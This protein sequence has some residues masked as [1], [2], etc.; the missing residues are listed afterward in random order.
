MEN[1]HF[2]RDISHV[3]M[4][5]LSTI[6][7]NIPA[8]A[9]SEAPRCHEKLRVLLHLQAAKFHVAPGA[10]HLGGG[11]GVCLCDFHGNVMAYTIPSGYVK[12]TIENSPFIVDLP[13]KDG[14][15]P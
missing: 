14:D 1:H 15:F 4:V 5:D 9:T 7:M 6:P 10:G 13:M 11:V 2:S 8:P 12:I 3:K